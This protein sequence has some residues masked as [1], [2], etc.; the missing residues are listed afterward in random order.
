MVCFSQ[1]PELSCRDLRLLEK[2]D[3]FL[4]S[5][6]RPPTPTDRNIFYQKASWSVCVQSTAMPWQ[7]RWPR[8]ILTMCSLMARGTQGALASPSAYVAEILPPSQPSPSS[9]KSFSSWFWVPGDKKFCLSWAWQHRTVV[10]VSLV[11]VGLEEP[12]VVLCL[13]RC[14]QPWPSK[15]EGEKLCLPHES[16]MPL[17]WLCF[18]VFALL[19]FCWCFVSSV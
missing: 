1:L 7:Q 9:Y 4:S 16:L 8:V 6:S 5:I 14:V 18:S 11:A 19:L 17:L 3:L 12:G 2:L 10:T 15:R 13:A